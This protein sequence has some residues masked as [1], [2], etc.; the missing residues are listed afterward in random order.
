MI[1]ECHP[2]DAVR[3]DVARGAR[4]AVRYFVTVGA[5]GDARTR[6]AFE[7]ARLLGWEAYAGE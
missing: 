5:T 2:E 3:R 1:D 6:D 4:S 7:D